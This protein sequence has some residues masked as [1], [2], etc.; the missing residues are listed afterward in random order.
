MTM[1]C[2]GVKFAYNIHFS[3]YEVVA[4]NLGVLL[5]QFRS[6]INCALFT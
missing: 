2:D 3:N 6:C 5:S 1:K 4:Y